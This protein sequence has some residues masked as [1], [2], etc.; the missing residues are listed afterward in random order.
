MRSVRFFHRSAGAA[1]SVSALAAVMLSMHVPHVKA[2]RTEKSTGDGY[3][4]SC[5]H[6]LNPHF[7]KS[8]S[9]AAA[10]TRKKSDSASR[11]LACKQAP[12]SWTSET[13]VSS[14]GITQPNAAAGGGDVVG[15]GGGFSHTDWSA[16]AQEPGAHM[17]RDEVQ[18]VG[19]R[20]RSHWRKLQVPEVKRLHE[21]ADSPRQSS[22]TA[23]FLSE[24]PELSVPC[25]R[26]AFSNNSGIVASWPCKL[27]ALCQFAAKLTVSAQGAE[28]ATTRAAN[29]AILL[30][31]AEAMSATDF[32][33]LS[34]HALEAVSPPETQNQRPNTTRA[35]GAWQTRASTWKN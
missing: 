26:T 13:L 12:Y 10:L 28:R 5:L 4:A 14:T 6:T 21:S 7:W 16:V 18:V 24:P 31:V 33:V 1:A 34:M 29:N 11:Q 8:L 17:Q 30:T 9:S 22:A 20:D 27:L 35:T 23:S 25:R 2:Q 15:F 3:F 19:P 32:Q